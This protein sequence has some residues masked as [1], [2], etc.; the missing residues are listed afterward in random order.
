MVRG[1]L[2][3]LWGLFSSPELREERSDKMLRW[4]SWIIKAIISAWILF[5]HFNFYQKLF[6]NW[7]VVTKLLGR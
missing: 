1:G 5:V 3:L 4:N 2:Y 6:E 7:Q